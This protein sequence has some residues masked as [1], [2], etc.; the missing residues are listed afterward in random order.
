MSPRPLRDIQESIRRL[1]EEIARIARRLEMLRAVKRGDAS[2]E[3]V[4]V[5]AHDVSAYHVRAHVR[6]V[7]RRRKK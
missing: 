4:R 2:L 7:A 5:K 3:R 6:Y 1:D